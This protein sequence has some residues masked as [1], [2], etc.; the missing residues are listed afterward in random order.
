MVID[1]TDSGFSD[2]T[3]AILRTATADYRPV[4]LH[5]NRRDESC[6]EIR[7]YNNYT[8][9]SKRAGRVR[10][11]FRGM[12]KL[13]VIDPRPYS[14]EEMQAIR[15]PRRFRLPRKRVSFS[16]GGADGIWATRVIEFFTRSPAIL[17]NMTSVT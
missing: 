15:W 16:A 13:E 6:D 7:Y 10:R 1:V 12:L 17:L 5:Q 9:M 8:N 4:V 2:G 14:E 3:K 11:P